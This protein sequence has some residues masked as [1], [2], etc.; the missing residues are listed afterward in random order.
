[1]I[2]VPEPDHEYNKR[3]ENHPNYKLACTTANT[4]TAIGG[5]AILLP[6]LMV[7]VPG[8][9]SWMP[10]LFPAMA[11]IMIGLMPIT[12]FMVIFFRGLMWYNFR[13]TVSHP[14]PIL[15][16]FFA[17]IGLLVA[18]LMESF[19]EYSRIFMIAGI[20]AFVFWIAMLL[21]TSEFKAYTKLDFGNMGALFFICFVFSFG[22]YT[23]S[24]CRFDKSEPQ[25]FPTTITN[26]KITEDNDHEESFYVYYKPVAGIDND[27][28]EVDE[29][30][31]KSVSVN[32]TLQLKLK[33]GLWGSKWYYLDKDD[34]PEN[35]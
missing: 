21:T 32:D 20:V 30:F 18:G 33:A 23:T 5:G 7:L 3:T 26:K 6:V 10:W 29:F 35:R 24:N 15:G 28:M 27:R 25:S 11:A 8:V 17:G 13:S 34:V 4:I 14:S 16:L 12:I 22:A 1:M 2:K 9:K 31:Y 19:M